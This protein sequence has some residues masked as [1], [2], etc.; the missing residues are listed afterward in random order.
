[1][2]PDYGGDAIYR[3]AGQTPPEALRYSG[4][5]DDELDAWVL[6]WEGFHDC[7]VSDDTHEE[8]ARRGREL[9]PRIGAVPVT[10]ERCQAD[11]KATFPLR[12]QR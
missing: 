9:R 3:I 10:I 1:M 5:L 4:H 12:P 8:W 7:R 6:E 2:M 11:A